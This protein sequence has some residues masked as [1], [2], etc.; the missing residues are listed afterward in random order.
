MLQNQS[1]DI[2][3]SREANANFSLALW[4]FTGINSLRQTKQ[5]NNKIN[6]Q[7][8]ERGYESYVILRCLCASFSKAGL[9][10]RK[11]KDRG[12]ASEY[13]RNSAHLDLG[14]SVLNPR[15]IRCK[16]FSIERKGQWY[17]TNICL[18]VFRDSSFFLRYQLSF[19]S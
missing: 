16:W 12:L 2:Q 17:V 9:E 3:S 4:K 18:G 5:K 1:L 11:A 14:Q 7:I 8:K 6:M 19:L 15:T 13:E 10:E